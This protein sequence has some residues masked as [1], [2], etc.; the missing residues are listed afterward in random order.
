MNLELHKAQS[1][2]IYHLF[3]P[4]SD[5]EARAVVLTMSRG[6]GKS[7]LASIVAAKGIEVLLNLPDDVLNKR[8]I[9][10]GPT[11]SQTLSIYLPY[12]NGI[13]NLS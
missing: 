12:L 13:L 10:V 9:I 1:Q 4:G 11:W 6:A 3:G 8:V 5:E 2:T 7:L